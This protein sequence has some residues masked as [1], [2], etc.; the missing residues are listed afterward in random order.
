MESCCVSTSRPLGERSRT[1]IGI[2]GAGTTVWTIRCR[3]NST[4]A[5]D[6]FVLSPPEGGLVV[7]LEKPLQYPCAEQ[8]ATVSQGEFT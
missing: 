7:S 5:V 6:L 2:R 4:L 3:A 1:E 8:A